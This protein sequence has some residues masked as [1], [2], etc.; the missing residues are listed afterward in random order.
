MQDSGEG[1]NRRLNL[2]DL[3][4][5]SEIKLRVLA[6]AEGPTNGFEETLG[7]PALRDGGLPRDSL[8][9][10]NFEQMLGDSNVG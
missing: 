10:Q 8:R 2:D 9:I 5:D 6:E 4:D 3:K 7:Q 1:R